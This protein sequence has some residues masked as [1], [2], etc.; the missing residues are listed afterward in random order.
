MKAGIC[1]LCPNCQTIISR[2]YCDC[3]YMEIKEFIGLDD[4]FRCYSTNPRH[5]AF[6]RD[7]RDI[8]PY[9][10]EVTPEIVSNAKRLAHAINSL[11]TQ[12]EIIISRDIKLSLT[13]GFRPVSYCKELGMST[14]SLHTKGLAVDISDIG[15]KKYDILEAL[16]RKDAPEDLLTKLGLW[17]EDKKATRTWLHLDLG[18]RRDR[19]IRIFLP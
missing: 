15:N 14:G 6:G 12:L 18:V 16:A 2:S 13:S 5:P 7:F 9:L 10:S 4:Y 8:P 3:G 11:F 17:M 19:P 1:R